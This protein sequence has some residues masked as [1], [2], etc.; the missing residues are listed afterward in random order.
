MSGAVGVESQWVSP[1]KHVVRRADRDLHALTT[2]ERG[3]DT[4]HW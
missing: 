3:E 2:G 4:P 1:G